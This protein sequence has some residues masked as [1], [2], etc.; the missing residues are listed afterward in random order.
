MLQI[1]EVRHNETRSRYIQKEV[2]T[3]RP[4]VRRLL[5][6]CINLYADEIAR[7]VSYAKRKPGTRHTAVKTLDQLK[8]STIASISARI[9]LNSVSSKKSYARLC[10]RVGEALEAEINFNKF[11]KINPT[12]AERSKERLMRTKVG[13]DFRKKCAYATMKRGGM[14]IKYLTPTERLHIGS[15]CL[16]LFI[17]QTGLVKVQKKWESPK[18]CVNM[19]VATDECMEWITKYEESKAYL[20]PR[21]YPCVQAPKPWTKDNHM[22]GYF[23]KQLEYSFVKTR[24]KE[25]VEAVTKR[26]NPRV[27]DAVNNMQRTAWRVNEWLF[28]VMK[29][30]WRG[31]LDEGGEMPMN[32]LLTIPPK[33]KP[34]SSLE[35]IKAY[36]RKSA[37]AYSKNAEYRS[38]RLA[39]AQIVY[40]AEKFKREPSLFFPCQVDF[41]GRIYYVTDHFNPQGSDYSRALLEFKEGEPLGIDGI[42]FLL[43]YGASLFG[44]KGS[45]EDCKIWAN[46]NR[47]K[48]RESYSNPWNQRWW[49]EA[50][51]PWQFLRWCKEF[52]DSQEK[53]NFKSHLPITLDC[54]SSGLQILSLLTGDK[55]SA[56][57]TNL[58]KR[59]APSDIYGKVLGEL[60]IILRQDDSSHAKFWLS[61]QLDRDLT[62]P[63][64]MTLPYG[65]TLYGIR[66]S[67]EK[68]Y[69]EKHKDLPHG[70]TD[71]WTST[72]YL[73]RKIVEAVRK[74]IPRGLEAMEW[75]TEVANNIAKANKPVCWLSPSGFM[76]VQPYMASNGVS[77]KTNLAGKIRYVLLQKENLKK[78]DDLR[79]KLSVSPNFI[80]SI[81]ASILHFALS[82]FD[83]NV[84]AIHDC[85]GTHANF[86]GELSEIVK[87]SMINIFKINVLEEFKECVSN[88]DDSI[89]LPSSFVRGDF[90]TGQLKEA[91]YI[92]V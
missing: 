49:Q 36:S 18:R 50:K 43:C 57:H 8:P 56:E 15:V 40:T 9:I 66:N 54:T 75:L 83:K 89:S 80:H 85:F 51:E 27:F 12:H 3:A 23:D 24:N 21:K 19:V 69:R 87:E 84:V 77:V 13:Y 92:F 32:K 14:K 38:K 4:A 74:F 46:T 90:D 37:Y 29:D 72:M 58:T 42:V 68:W 71:F 60:Q 6:G 20:Q 22:G 5:A 30:F 73:S 53:P 1:G 88:I 34:G 78:I 61:K 41:R 59:D 86:V 70:M 45:K 48:I 63:V 25:V 76:V 17:K 62:K 91:Q 65:A 10:I 7:W 2:E 35:E 81:D 52:V 26:T 55:T 82:K 67:V 44:I 64:C 28:D 33:P 16:D 11:R 31:G 39:L 47:Q 79:Q